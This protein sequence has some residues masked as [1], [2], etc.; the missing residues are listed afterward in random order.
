[1]KVPPIILPI[2]PWHYYV[3]K[4]AGPSEEFPN[5]QF[6][7]VWKMLGEQFELAAELP[8]HKPE[9]ELKNA[10]FDALREAV[11]LQK[12]FLRINVSDYYVSGNVARNKENCAT[13]DKDARITF[14]SKKDAGKPPRPFLFINRLDNLIFPLELHTV[15]CQDLL[16]LLALDVLHLDQS[17]GDDVENA[18]VLSQNGCRGLVRMLHDLAHLGVDL[19]RHA[20]GIL[21]IIHTSPEHRSSG[22]TLKCDRSEGLGHSVSSYHVSRH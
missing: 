11:I 3:I 16:V 8:P 21:T 13:I 18:S 2:L 19:R 12:A 15:S 7:E 10:S 20:L 5:G 9:F 1:M 6:V 14:H 22:L 17:L 4:V